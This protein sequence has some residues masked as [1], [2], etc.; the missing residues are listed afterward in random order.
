MRQSRLVSFRNCWAGFHKSRA[1][2]SRP[3]SA[4][5]SRSGGG[6]SGMIVLATRVV[7]SW[8]MS[9]RTFGGGIMNGSP[10]AHA[11]HANPRRIDQDE[12]AHPR[13]VADRELGGEPAA[14]RQADDVDPVEPE[15]VQHV[16]RVEDQILHRLDRVEALGSAESRVNGQ[17]DPAPGGETIVDGHPP[18][19]AR[20]VEIDE[21]LAP[22]TLEQL[23]PPPVDG[24][25]ALVIRARRRLLPRSARSPRSAGMPSAIVCTESA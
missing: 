8:N 21:R 18:E 14:E 22:A 25:G 15:G 19:G 5:S 2:A 3:R 17:E 16:E 12:A 7:G 10:V 24:Q 20:A 4:A 1:A 11:R 6:A 13:G 23:D 9:S